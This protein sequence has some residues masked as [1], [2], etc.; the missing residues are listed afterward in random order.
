MNDFRDRI[1][2]LTGIGRFV[3]VA[4]IARDLIVTN[5]Q[6]LTG[7]TINVNPALVGI[8]SERSKH[9]FNILKISVET[10]RI[11]GLTVNFDNGT[12]KNTLL[13]EFRNPQILLSHT[14]SLC[15]NRFTVCKELMYYYLEE[16]ATANK[17]EKGDVGK[18]LISKLSS[19]SGSFCEIKKEDDLDKEQFTFCLA[20]EVMLPWVWR[21]EVH[22][23][24]EQGFT[25]KEIA[26]RF[27]VPEAIIE[28]Y[29]TSGYKE[30]SIETNTGLDA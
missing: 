18:D 19:I 7:K 22:D 29:F 25:N 8:V 13:E 28:M 17:P 9:V 4:L 27:K 14:N 5:K 6:L 24:N 20:I 3:D 26:T 1:S 2:K 15:W 11:S 12:P 23:M 30:L 16:T 10:T 21:D